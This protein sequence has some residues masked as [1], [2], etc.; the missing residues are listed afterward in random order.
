M[1]Q[2]IGVLMIFF[3]VFTLGGVTFVRIEQLQKLGLLR[4]ITLLIGTI[5]LVGLFLLGGV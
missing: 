4:E 2:T 1:R 3:S 5:A